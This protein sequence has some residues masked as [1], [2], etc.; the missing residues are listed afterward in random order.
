MGSVRLL[1]YGQRQH[2]WLLLII[3]MFVCN[4]LAAAQFTLSGDAAH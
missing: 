3:I 1:R 2:G 4:L